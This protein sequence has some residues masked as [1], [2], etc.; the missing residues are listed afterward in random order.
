MIRRQSI[1]CLPRELLI[2]K[3]DANGFEISSL[4]LMSSLFKW[5]SNNCTKERSGKSHLVIL[6]KQRVITKNEN[7]ELESQNVE[8]LLGTDFDSTLTLE[9]HS[10]KLMPLPEISIHDLRKKE[11]HNES[12][13]YITF[14]FLIPSLD[15]A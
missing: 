14:W 11:S 5:F 6:E 13:Y 12:F 7:N 2:A 15:A 10:Q 8:E 1:D 4:K 9:N 3:I